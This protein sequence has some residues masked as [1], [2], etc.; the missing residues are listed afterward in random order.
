MSKIESQIRTYPIELANQD[1][2]AEHDEIVR[3]LPHTD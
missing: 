2:E 3:H 1:L